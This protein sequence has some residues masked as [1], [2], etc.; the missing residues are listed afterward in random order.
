MKKRNKDT[1]SAGTSSR[2]PGEKTEKEC[3]ITMKKLIAV[4]MTLILSALCLAGAAADNEWTDYTCAE[5]KFSTQIP[6]DGTAVYE[7]GTGLV[8]YTEKSGSIPYVIVSRR[9]TPVSDP[10]N[11]LNNT[12]REHLEEK[13]G[14]DYIAMNEAKD[15]TLGGKT[16]TG[17]LYMYKVKDVTIILIRLIDSREDGDVEYTIKYEKDKD[18]QRSKTMAAANTA[19]RSY[20]TE[21]NTQQAKP[22]EK[23]AASSKA[24]SFLTAATFRDQFNAAMNTLADMYSE[25]LGEEGVAI[26]KKDYIITQS[27]PQGAL[28]YYGNDAWS[29]EAGFSYA[30]VKANG[31]NDPAVLMNFSISKKV[32]DGASYLATSAFKMIIGF[33]FQDTVTLDDLTA[34]FDAEPDPANIF[35][36]PGGY[37]LNVL[38][39]NDYYQY[40]ILPPADQNPFLE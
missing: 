10:V 22:E 19:V 2:L 8:I 12:Y 1:G 4:L 28:V 34:W 5:E 23:P 9:P 39:N 3:L 24:P 16:L 40:A 21:G 11:Y 30:D 7:E 32:P 38:P 35:A 27:D 15:W 37:T 18:E 20:Q 26:V 29:V 13:Y 31:A 6:A 33:E 17:A 14:N 36:L 25:A